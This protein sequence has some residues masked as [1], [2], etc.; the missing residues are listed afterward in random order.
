MTKNFAAKY[1]PTDLSKKQVSD[2][3]MAVVL[4]FLIT[5]YFTKKI[6]YY[7]IAIPFLVINMAIPM[8]YYPFAVIWLG[9]TNLLG[10][11]VSK[12]LLATV[13][14]VVLFPVSMFRRLTGKDSLSLKGFK[15]ATSS[16]MVTRDHTF[17]AKD[18]EHPY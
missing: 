14:F 8:F 5:G 2:S 4:L 16:V 3:G 12:V 7:K 1:F 10:E 17:T 13:Y 9:L 6:I 18:I 11:I 15:K